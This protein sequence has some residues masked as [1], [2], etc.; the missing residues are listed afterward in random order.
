M[1]DLRTK[2]WTPGRPIE[3]SGQV[4]DQ[5]GHA[6]GLRRQHDYRL[7][8]LHDRC[9]LDGWNACGS[10]RSTG[11]IELPRTQSISRCRRVT[12]ACNGAGGRVVFEVT[13]KRVGLPMRPVTRQGLR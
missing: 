6:I 3:P 4:Q 13:Q 10:E 2:A 11:P 1:K 9:I 5:A 8:D 7:R 12:N